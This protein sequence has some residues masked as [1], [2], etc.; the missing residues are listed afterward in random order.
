MA[1]IYGFKAIRSLSG[2][3]VRVNEY[4]LASGTQAIYKGDLVIQNA[5]GKVERAASSATSTGPFLGVAME[6]SPSTA[7]ASDVMLVCDDPHAIFTV[8]AT[9]AIAQ[10]G[11]NLNYNASVADGSS[12]LRQSQCRLGAALSASLTTGIK[13]IG[14][15]NRPDNT[16]NSAKQE[17]LCVINNH[18]FKAGTAGI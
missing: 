9:A 7:S 6:D 8:V 12:T 1:E 15:V 4:A 2:A 18:V 3:E 14:Y 5:N 13:V 17:V 10:T 11:I 16:A